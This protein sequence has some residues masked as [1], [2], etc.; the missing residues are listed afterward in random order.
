MNNEQDRKK[1]FQFPPPRGGELFRDNQYRRP[2]QFQFPPPRGGEPRHNGIDIT[3][4]ISIPAPA[5]GRTGKKGFSGTIS[6]ISIPAPARG[7][8]IGFPGNPRSGNISIPA[9]ARGRTETGDS[10]FYLHVDFN[11]RPREG[12]NALDRHVNL[13]V[14]ISIP[15]PARG[16]TRNIIPGGKI[17]IISIPAP[18]RGRTAKFW[19]IW[20]PSPNFNSRPREGANKT[21]LSAIDN[22]PYFNSRPREGANCVGWLPLPG[23]PDFNSRPREGANIVHCPRSAFG[24][25]FNSRPREG[26][27]SKTAQNRAVYL[28]SLLKFGRISAILPYILSATHAK[29]RETPKIIGFLLR[30]PTCRSCTEQVG[31]GGVR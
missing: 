20:L 23:Y 18:A 11:S 5:R 6:T 2:G 14:A 31:A 15:A 28:V 12:A 17:L 3:L 22:F 25:Y 9:P 7:R 13:I 21:F 24:L 19:L 27:N 8:T 29:K 30:R 26:A 1:I 4:K 16:R 10:A